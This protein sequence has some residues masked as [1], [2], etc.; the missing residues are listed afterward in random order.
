MRIFIHMKYK[1]VVTAYRIDE[2]RKRNKLTQ[3]YLAHY[4]GVTQASISRKLAGKAPFTSP[5]VK[6]CSLLLHTS[7]DYLL[8]LQESASREVVA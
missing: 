6:S 4:L 2:Q 8:G 7:T 5:E 3:E 1:D